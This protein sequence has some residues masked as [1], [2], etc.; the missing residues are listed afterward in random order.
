MKISKPEKEAALIKEATF[1]SHWD[2]STCISSPCKVNMD[3]KEVFD[4]ETASGI[5]GVEVLDNEDVVIDDVQH[6]VF[7]ADEAGPNDYW[8]KW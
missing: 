8:Y 1:E 6:P 7:R 4:I 3:T 5:E 2:G